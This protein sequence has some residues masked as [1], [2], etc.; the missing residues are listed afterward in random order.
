MA[1]DDGRTGQSDP[2]TSKAPSSALEEKPSLEAG[3]SFKAA[4]RQM[5]LHHQSSSGLQRLDDINEAA[6]DPLGLAQEGSGDKAFGSGE[7]PAVMASVFSLPPASP[8]S[9]SSPFAV[10]AGLAPF[11]GGPPSNTAPEGNP[12]ACMQ[13]AMC[14]SADRTLK[15]WL[16]QVRALAS[17][18]RSEGQLDGHAAWMQTHERLY[19]P[20]Y[21]PC[22]SAWMPSALK[23]QALAFPMLHGRD[24]HAGQSDHALQK[25][26]YA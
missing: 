25:Q 24:S 20:E 1:W 18:C 10:M 3:H 8:Q 13:Q 22:W 6:T 17:L 14:E 15:H 16:C 7:L 26:P 5:S 9:T 2:R 19:C 11:A 21:M 12:I 4:S 23:W